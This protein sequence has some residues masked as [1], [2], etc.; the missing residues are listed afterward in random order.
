MIAH[1]IALA[2]AAQTASAVPDY[3]PSDGGEIDPDYEACIAGLAEN[4]VKG[5]DAASKWYAE[6]GGAPALHC[7]A[8]ADLAAGH[9]KLSAVHLEELADR[10]DAGDKLVRARILSQAARAWLEAGEN[11]FAEKALDAAFA[12][13]PGAGELYLVKAAVK[14]AQGEMQATIDAVTEA[15]KQGV[16][17]P[18]GY[19]LRGRA[20]HALARNREAADDVVAALKLDP[21]NVDA[22]TLRGDLHQ[23]G[24]DIKTHYRSADDKD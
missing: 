23:A 4:V 20:L 15:E 2:L 9:P 6:G 16:T 10:P 14:F 17:A 18:E 24:V 21:L 5:R 7:L 13:A 12:D 8:V 22:L 1:L 19:V 3:P 11:D